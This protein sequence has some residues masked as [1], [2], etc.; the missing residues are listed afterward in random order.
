MSCLP[1]IRPTL[2]SRT[3]LPLALTALLMLSSSSASGQSVDSLVALAMA[4]HPVFETTRLRISALDARAESALALDPPKIGLRSSMLPASRPVPFLAGE[5]MLTAQQSLPLGD[6]RER[7]ADAITA[8][9]GVEMIEP[10]LVERRLRRMIRTGLAEAREAERRS[11]LMRE[12]RQVLSVL[13]RDAEARLTVDVIPAEAIYELALEIERIDADLDLLAMRRR[14]AIAEINLLIGRD[15]STPID[16]PDPYDGEIPPF[17][18]LRTEL[19]NHPRLLRLDSLAATRLAEAD[20]AAASLES[21]L[22]LSAGVGWMPQGHPVR[23]DRLPTMIG[24]IT[25]GGEP[26]VERIGFDL[27]AMI[28][29]PIAGWSRTGPEKREEASRIAAEA[30]RS[31]SGTMLREMAADLRDALGMIERSDRMILFYR[32]RQIPLLEQRIELLRSRYLVDRT[33]FT[34]LVETY[35]MVLATREEIALRRATRQRAL[36]TIEELTGTIDGISE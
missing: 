19:R 9:A 11:E 33:S 13:Y 30:V 31:E 10:M 22:T 1:N 20:A 6:R 24:E 23:Q 17:D 28:S 21:T 36:A 35:R 4:D 26:G 29:L 15:P 5:T 32:D 2:K 25:T 3:L 16:L 18:E 34:E 12:S 14:E 7:Q 8:A 27:G